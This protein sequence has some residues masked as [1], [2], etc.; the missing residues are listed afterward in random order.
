LPRNEFRIEGEVV[1][2]KLTQGKETCVDLADWPQVQRLRWFTRRRPH[3]FYVYAWHGK[4]R[5]HIPL[6]RLITGGHFP[7]VDH[8]DGNG[9]NNQRSN[10]RAATTQE[11]NRNCKLRV[12]NLSGFK[13]VSWSRQSKKWKAQ[14]MDSGRQLHLGVFASL[15]EAVECYDEK[16][17]SLFGAFTRPNF[18]A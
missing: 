7:Q 13:G 14:I 1:W 6:H 12:T 11:N 5:E 2:I 16:A 9:L 4:G 8:K 15:L 17:K 10:L 3:T 18:S